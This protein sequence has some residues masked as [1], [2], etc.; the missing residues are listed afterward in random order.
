MDRT[1]ICNLG[2]SYQKFGQVCKSGRRLWSLSKC[3]LNYSQKVWTKSFLP[4]QQKTKPPWQTNNFL[5]WVVLKSLWCLL[6]FF[7]NHQLFLFMSAL[8]VLFENK[9]QTLHICLHEVIVCK[10]ATEIGQLLSFCAVMWLTQNARGRVLLNDRS[11][12][13]QTN[14]LE[15]ACLLT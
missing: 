4:K 1:E 8:W 10:I 9:D 2:T 7:L 5:I 11:Q 13:L 12:S 14:C 3:L 15:A 6:G